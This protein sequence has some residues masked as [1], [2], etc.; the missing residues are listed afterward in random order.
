MVDFR[1]LALMS[2]VAASCEPPPQ[3]DL[4][5]RVPPRCVL[6]MLRGNRC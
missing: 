4:V 1:L 6:A 2:Q 3:P 5:I